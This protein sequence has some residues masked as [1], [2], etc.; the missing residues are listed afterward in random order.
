MLLRP[1]ACDKDVPGR[2]R[3]YEICGMG[4]MLCFEQQ[5]LRE[6]QGQLGSMT[7]LGSSVLLTRATPHILRNS[8]LSRLVQMIA[9]Y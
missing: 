9:G 6:K 5:G 2:S 4:S 7:W 1:G 3:G 8:N